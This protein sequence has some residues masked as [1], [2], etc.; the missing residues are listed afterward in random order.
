M[1]QQPILTA[2][3]VLEMLKEKLPHNK[4]WLLSMICWNWK[5]SLNDLGIKL[6]CDEEIVLLQR[7]ADFL[8]SK[9]IF[10]YFKYDQTQPNRFRYYR[11]VAGEC[12]RVFV[13]LGSQGKYLSSIFL[14]IE[15]HKKTLP[16]HLLAKRD[17]IDTYI[18]KIVSDFLWVLWDL[19]MQGDKEALKTL[20]E[21]AWKFA[22][23]VD[24]FL[25]SIEDL[26][27]LHALATAL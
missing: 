22:E 4:S 15:K 1:T 17:E 19:Y 5:H 26:R 27:R 3:E 14:F 12:G 9:G 25:E 8:Q 21:E 23:E 11:F 2:D 24:A 20:C 18:D 13:K 7:L 10:V 16:K 6:T